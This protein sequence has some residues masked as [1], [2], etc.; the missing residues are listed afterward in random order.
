MNLGRIRFVE[1]DCIYDRAQYERRVSTNK[2][3]KH[4]CIPLAV[5]LFCTYIIHVRVYVKVSVLDC[6]ALPECYV[7]KKKSFK[8]SI[9]VGILAIYKC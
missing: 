5:F 9:K 8:K 1:S 6:F 2:K 7:F 4:I 3:K